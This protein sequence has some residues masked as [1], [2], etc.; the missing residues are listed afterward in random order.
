MAPRSTDQNQQ[1]RDE[2]RE[3]ILQAALGVFARRGLAATKIGDIAAAV[4]LSHGLVYHYFAS[5][6][7]VFTALVERALA[8]AIW[9]AR[10]AAEQPGTPWEQLRWLTAAI[11]AGDRQQAEYVLIMLQAFTSDAVPETVKQLAAEKGPQI[12]QYTIPLVEA[13]QAAGQ[14][15]AGDPIRLTVAYYALVQGL[16]LG[17]VHSRGLY[18]EPDV[19]LVLRLLK[20]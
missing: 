5:K 6:D 18:P 17:Q 8:G 14:V 3:Q 11:M 20:A 13:G 19:D 2:R 1:I 12:Y 9:V 15:A 10:A 16:A 4:G 7:E